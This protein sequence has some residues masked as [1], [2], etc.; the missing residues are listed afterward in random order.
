MAGNSQNATLAWPDMHR[1]NI[2]KRKD[3]GS[4]IV[5]HDINSHLVF[6]QH[7]AFITQTRTYTLV[8]SPY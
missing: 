2:L 1:P 4:S 3:E 8:G 5:A 6:V 7:T